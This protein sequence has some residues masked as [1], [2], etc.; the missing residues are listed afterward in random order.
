M[1]TNGH[2]WATAAEAKAFGERE[3]SRGGRLGQHVPDDRLPGEHPEHHPEP[4]AAAAL[5][6]RAGARVVRPAGHH[7]PADGFPGG[8]LP[9]P[10][11]SDRPRPGAGG[12]YF[13][14][15]N[16]DRQRKRLMR[17]LESLGLKVTVE[18]LKEAA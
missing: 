6:Q 18:E 2:G 12:D 13:D 8:L 9:P 3:G 15:R 4:S 17:Q 1:N 16:G 11:R 7:H 10:H 5:A 14:R